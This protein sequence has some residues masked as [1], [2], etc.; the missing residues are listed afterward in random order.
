M[1]IRY[2]KRRAD[3]TVAYYDSEEQMQADELPAPGL[4]DF[5]LLWAVIGFFVSVFLVIVVVYGLDLGIGWPKALRFSAMI[6][7]V[8]IGTYAIG[9]L[10]QLLFYSFWVVAG[11]VLIIGI[12][13]GIV[14]AIWHLA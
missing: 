10:G 7:A 12:I 5:S 8:G 14:A 11:I 4:F 2:S 3:G 6:T 9:R 13:G 1:A